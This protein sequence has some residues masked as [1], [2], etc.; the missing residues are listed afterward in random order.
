MKLFKL[1][2]SIHQVYSKADNFDPT[3]LLFVIATGQSACFEPALCQ[4]T[5]KV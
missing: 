3:L 1:I 2:S 4:V 5:K